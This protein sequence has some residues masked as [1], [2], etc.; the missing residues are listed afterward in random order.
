MITATSL[1]ADADPR[2]PR[3][4]SR[5]MARIAALGALVLSTLL[6][7]CGGGGAG[8]V[9]NGSGGHIAVVA[10]E[11]FWGSVVAQLGGD[12][13]SVTSVVTDPN[14]DPHDY[15]TSASTARA[16]ATAGYVVV[17][18]A[19]YDGWADSLLDANPTGN[20][21]VLHVDDLLGQ[22][23][24]ENPHFWYTPA[25]VERV[26]DRITN[27]LASI[28]PAHAAAYTTRRTSFEAALAPYHAAITAIRS[29][30][31]GAKVASTESIFEGMAAALGL[32]LIS[33]PELMK[34]VAE[35]NDPPADALARFQ[36]Q[37]E[38]RAATVLVYN[39]Q[40]STDVTTNLRKLADDHGI[41]VVGITETIQPANASFQAWMTAELTAIQTALRTASGR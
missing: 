33:P 8:G 9:A 39:E 15:Q 2:R 11:N 23:H 38:S 18:G 40:T 10:A 4:G 26:A 17:N 6:A 3:A 20:R 16:F 32:D 30:F 5:R 35:G 19:G 29:R 31:S 41:A 13:V 37:L 34:A 36:Q 25:Y 28:D 22:R 1:S 7:A 14:A 27:D 24:A 21:T 12:D